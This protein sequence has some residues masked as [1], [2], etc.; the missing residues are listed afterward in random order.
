V[1]A[2]MPASINKTLRSLNNNNNNNMT[3]Y[4]AP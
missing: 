3:T 4:K 2:V 1:T